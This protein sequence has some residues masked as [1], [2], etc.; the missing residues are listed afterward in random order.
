MK[1]HSNTEN[2]EIMGNIEN[3]EKMKKYARS[4]C[5]FKTELCKK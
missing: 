4:T 5:R 2:I 1:G 3:I